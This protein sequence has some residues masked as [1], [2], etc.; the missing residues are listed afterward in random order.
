MTYPGWS[1]DKPT[2]HVSSARDRIDAQV[3]QI[4]YSIYI[5]SLTRGFLP[6]LNHFGSLYHGYMN[7]EHYKITWFTQ[8]KIVMQV[9]NTLTPGVAIDWNNYDYK[10][11]AFYLMM[12]RIA[13][14]QE[15]DWPALVYRQ[16]SGKWHHENGLSRLVTSGF[17][18]QDPW[19]RYRVI[20]QELPNFLP[21]DVLFNYQKISS[22]EDLH[23]ILNLTFDRNTVVP[24]VVK[25]GSIVEEVD[26]CTRV[27]LRY[28]NDGEFKDMVNA[29]AQNL[30]LDF[31]EWR[32]I[33]GPRPKLYVYTDDPKLILD[34]SNS[35]EIIHVG[36]VPSH[37]IFE[38]S[39]YHYTQDPVHSKDHVLY[40]QSTRKI[41]VGD[42]LT[43][44]GPKYSSYIGPDWSFAL[45]RPAEQYK[46]LLI[47][48][49]Y[50]H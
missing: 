38:S 9:L 39:L 29:E 3:G 24:P 43:W 30:L 25:I 45:F 7:P 17:C 26:S 16:P 13:I 5:S 1:P 2:I 46:S 8:W 31:L 48:V 40:H 37:K 42:F 14:K 50:L 20:F 22:D 21:D 23:Q 10:S 19:N 12:L 6:F 4:E 18:Q 47:D 32:K 11:V 15:W 28:I 49:S 33:Y 41:D 34:K 27:R 44:V 35:W 36:S